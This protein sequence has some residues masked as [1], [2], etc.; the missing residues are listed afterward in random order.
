MRIVLNSFEVSEL[1]KQDPSTVDDGGYQQLLVKLQSKLNRKDNS[2]ILDDD[3][4]EKIPRYAF[5]YGQGGWEDRLMNIF[6][7]SL[8]SRLGR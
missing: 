6:S 5:D 8:G 3:D 1:L 2:I 4:L 7:R